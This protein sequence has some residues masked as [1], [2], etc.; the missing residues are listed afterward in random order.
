MS[1]HGA[2]ERQVPIQC[3]AFLRRLLQLACRIAYVLGLG[4]LGAAWRHTCLV[5]SDT[6]GV[7]W[8]LDVFGNFHVSALYLADA[9]VDLVGCSF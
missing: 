4:N 1:P 5:R 3:V 9:P 8:S 2:T 6:F 7:L